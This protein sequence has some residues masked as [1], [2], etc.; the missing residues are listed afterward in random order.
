MFLKYTK[1]CRYWLKYTNL[2]RG[3]R[4]VG[5]VYSLSNVKYSPYLAYISP[6]MEN[7]IQMI[8]NNHL[9]GADLFR[10]ELNV[11]GTV[12]FVLNR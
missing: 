9:G 6:M 4:G 1:K 3:G 5:G 7:R 2:R 12:S 11:S 8:T 10:R